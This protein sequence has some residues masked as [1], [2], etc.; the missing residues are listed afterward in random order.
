VARA[1]RYRTAF[2]VAVFDIDHFKQV[3]DTHGPQA[4]DRM[5]VHVATVL[6]AASRVSDTIGRIGGE[7]FVALLTEQSAG[8]AVLAARRLRD[9][10]GRSPPP[11]RL[12]ARTSYA[13]GASTE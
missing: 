7:E 10:V 1:A 11:G 5:L 9:E 2:A 8:D 6:K 13:D 12:S 3:N 4:G